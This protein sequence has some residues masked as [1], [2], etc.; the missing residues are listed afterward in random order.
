MEIGFRDT[1]RIPAEEVGMGGKVST[2]V[3]VAPHADRQ[4]VGIDPDKLERNQHRDC[5]AYNLSVHNHRF[6]LERA[7]TY[8]SL[9]EG[10]I[11][12]FPIRASGTF[13][14]EKRTNAGK[15]EIV[16]CAVKWIRDEKLTAAVLPA[17]SVVFHLSG[18][19]VQA[20]DMV[21]NREMCLCP[22]HRA[23]AIRGVGGVLWPIVLTNCELGGFLFHHQVKFLESHGLE[24]LYHWDLYSFDCLHIL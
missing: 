22:R 15:L 11:P 13:G 10:G 14:S 18:S 8:H 21:H 16:V 2:F 7:V 6:A 4:I 5:P 12:G 23:V 9:K 20:P 24:P 1:D 19:Q 3:E 17:P